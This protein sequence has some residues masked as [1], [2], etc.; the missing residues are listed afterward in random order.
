MGFGNDEEDQK[1]WHFFFRI[2]KKEQ[3]L[4]GS[5]ALD[6]VPGTDLGVF[7]LHVAVGVIHRVIL[8]LQVRKLRLEVVLGLVNG[9][10]C[11]LASP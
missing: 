5:L 3:A 7:T 8:I 2:E 10:V 9:G 6:C 4:F 11:K 1:F